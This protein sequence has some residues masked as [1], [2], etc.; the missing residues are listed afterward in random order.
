MGVAAQDQVDL[1][2][3]GLAVDMSFE[4]NN[5]CNLRACFADSEQGKWLAEHAAQFGFIIRY[6][7]GAKLLP[8]TP[9]SRGIFATS[10]SRRLST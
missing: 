6:P 5:D 1:S 4:D 3:F 2:P 10:E 9:M 8:A 7:E